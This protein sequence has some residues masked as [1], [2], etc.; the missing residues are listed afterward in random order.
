MIKKI[1]LWTFSVAVAILILFM[2]ES[3]Y[4][5][6]RWCIYG[7][8]MLLYLIGFSVTIYSL[9]KQYYYGDGS[10]EGQDVEH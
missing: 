10:K 9:F 2:P 4:A 1:V 3:V 6:Y 8:V 5:E 7:G